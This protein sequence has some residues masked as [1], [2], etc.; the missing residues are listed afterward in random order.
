MAHQLEVT[1]AAMD[2]LTRRRSRT[3]ESSW[4]SPVP[5]IAGS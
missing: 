5:S 1:Q 3:R 4:S 2:D